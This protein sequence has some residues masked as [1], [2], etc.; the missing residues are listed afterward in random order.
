MR[1]IRES[2]RFKYCLYAIASWPTE[3]VACGAICRWVGKMVNAA[4]GEVNVSHQL[5]RLEDLGII[6]RPST[7]VYRL[8]NPLLKAYVILKARA[9]TPENELQA[10]DAHIVEIRKR[11]DSVI[12]RLDP[13]ESG[14]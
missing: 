1:S 2:P 9:D 7:G 10:I 8:R 3:P 13:L 11:L 12:E 4:S 14:A 5:K 6:E